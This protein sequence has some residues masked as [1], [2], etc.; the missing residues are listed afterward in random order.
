MGVYGVVQIS[1]K[2]EGKKN[3]LIQRKTTRF[4]MNCSLKSFGHHGLILDQLLDIQI[5]IVKSFVNFD[6]EKA[7]Q[8]NWFDAKYNI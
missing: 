1:F 4:C 8:S 2:E 5:I 3:H 6:I 7:W